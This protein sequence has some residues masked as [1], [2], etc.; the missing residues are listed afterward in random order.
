MPREIKNL[1][2]DARF[3]DINKCDID[4]LFEP[5]TLSKSNKW[6]VHRIKKWGREM[7]KGFWLN[8]CFQG[9]E[10]E[11]QIFRGAIGK[12]DEAFN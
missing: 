8:M 12:T 1:V 4:E 10:F 6:E 5:P 2:K 11:Y 3:Y 9:E 7:R